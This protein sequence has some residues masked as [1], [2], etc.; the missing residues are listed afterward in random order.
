MHLL[1]EKWKSDGLIIR[2]ASEVSN[3]N[4]VNK[5]MNY[6][7]ENFKTHTSIRLVCV[8]VVFFWYKPS[9]FF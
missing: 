5:I 6:N 7:T 1:P 2:L 4:K 8:A 3:Q 9:Q